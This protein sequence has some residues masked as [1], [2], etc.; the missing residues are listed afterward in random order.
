MFAY[1]FVYSDPDLVYDKCIQGE[2]GFDDCQDMFPAG[3]KPGNIL[4]ELSGE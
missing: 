4:P 1:F 3:Y 2:E